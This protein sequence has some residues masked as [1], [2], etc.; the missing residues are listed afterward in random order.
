LF[1][2]TSTHDGG[3]P[4]QFRCEAGNHNDSRTHEETWDALCSAAGRK[5]FLYVADTKLCNGEA[6]EYIDRRGGRFVTVIPRNRREDPLFR[7]WIQTHEPEWEN[8][9]DRCNPRKKWGPRDRWYVFKDRLPSLEGWP[10][11]WV[12][13]TLLRQKQAHS[14]KD[15]IARA[16][17]ELGDLASHHLGPRPRRRARHEVKKQIDE[18]ID[19]LHVKRYV[20][21]KLKHISLHSYKQDRPGRPGPDTK[22]SRKT[23]KRWQITWSLDEETVAYDHKSDGMY[24]LLTNDR[25]LS[26]RQVLEAHKR[27]PGIEKRFE[28]TKTVMEI[29]PVFLKNEGRIEAFFFLYFLALL[30]QALIEREIR[31]AM[32][33]E[34]IAELP[35]YPEERANSRPT[36]EQILRLF[37]NMERHTL[38][39]GTNELQVFEPEFTELQKIVLRLLDVPQAA[40]YRKN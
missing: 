34:G 10:V 11:I 7:E 16:E 2:L 4:V 13:S 1:I 14:R 22:Y 38:L 36:T 5:D 20:K 33:A 40:F 39:D 26:P 29:A 35:L 27:Q 25:S 17:Q 30:V 9:W 28:Q 23:K 24:P 31:L 3:V 32:E 18:I 6:M 15:R 37:S 12:Y 19:R 21:V 8:V